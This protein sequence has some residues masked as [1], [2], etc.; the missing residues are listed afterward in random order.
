MRSLLVLTILLLSL[1]KTAFGQLIFESYYERQLIKEDFAD[2]LDRAGRDLQKD[3][4]DPIALYYKALVLNKK[5]YAGFQPDSAYQC[6]QL[7]IPVFDRADKRIL[8][9]WEKDGLSDTKLSQLLASVDENTFR[10]YKDQQRVEAMEMF[11]DRYPESD[12]IQDAKFVLYELAFMEAASGDSASDYFRF[13]DIYPNAPQVSRARELAELRRYQENTASGKL[14]DYMIFV[15]RY[16][17]SPFRDQAVDHIAEIKL[18]VLTPENIHWMAENFP[19]HPSLEKAR[20][21]LFHQMKYS[22]APY[23][24]NDS[25]KEVVENQKTPKVISSF[26]DM[27]GIMRIDGKILLNYAYDSIITDG[28]T[29]QALKLGRWTVLNQD[30]DLLGTYDEPATIEALPQGWYKLN[31]LYVNAGWE[32][33]VSYEALIPDP[34]GRF[35]FVKKYGTW[36]EESL[37]GKLAGDAYDSIMTVGLSI[38]KLKNKVWQVVHAEN[39]FTGDPFEFESFDKL[40]DGVFLL[41]KEA[42]TYIWQD[43]ERKDQLMRISE[44]IPMD[45]GKYILVTNAG[46]EYAY[47]N[48]NLINNQAAAS[49]GFSGQNVL[50]Q[51][52]SGYR[53]FTPGGKELYGSEKYSEIASPFFI[54]G[55]SLYALAADGIPFDS[56]QQ[57]DPVYAE[58][59]FCTHITITKNDSF[60]IYDRHL[61][62]I[63]KGGSIE[64]IKA[65]SENILLNKADGKTFVITEDTAY[66]FDSGTT[67]V[68]ATDESVHLLRENKF[69][70][71]NIRSGMLV[72]PEYDK[73]IR[74]LNAN[75]AAVT[76]EEKTGLWIDKNQVLS[77]EFSTVAYFNDSV[78]LAKNKKWIIFTGN[79]TLFSDIDDYQIMQ[80]GIYLSKNGNKGMF[81]EN[82]TLDPIFE[83]IKMFD[84]D[85]FETWHIDN[86][87]GLYIRRIIHD[88]GKVVYAEAATEKSFRKISSL[89]K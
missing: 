33:P 19:D 78:F 6:L 83:T 75:A 9:K 16:P 25:V 72:S 81:H 17:Y 26:Y 65:L 88:S 50:A 69:G 49:V 8:E 41:H 55:D 38:F 82:F 62:L 14:E 60:N 18:S 39:Y 85:H 5:N 64:N 1:Q 34:M 45:S 42:W 74:P 66:F 24:Y 28:N 32:E 43:D 89:Y 29:F 23:L 3:P 76:K 87:S 22:S 13:I 70:Y 71:L 48:E 27:Y 61:R 54:L 15:E 59:G 4:Y 7:L 67:I 80:E 37:L 58:G 47:A 57:I 68:K 63:W 2:I 51:Y 77:P 53:L 30:L 21:L 36:R 86:L 46:S 31:E 84:Y 10:Y 35:L 40:E 73:L 79:D 11:M 12:Y 20:K 56:T 44:V 52:T